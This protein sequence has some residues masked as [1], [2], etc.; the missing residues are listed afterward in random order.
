MREPKHTCPFIDG[1]I[2]SA[3]ADWEDIRSLNN[4]LRDWG[5]YWQDE[6][7]TMEEIKNDEIENLKD[8]IR[9]LKDKI[10]ELESELTE[11]SQR[12]TA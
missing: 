11:V 8:A 6:Y 2:R 7:E 10:S 3:A 12:E 9:D 5:K 1:A 4:E